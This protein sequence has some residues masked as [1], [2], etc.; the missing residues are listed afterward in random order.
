MTKSRRRIFVFSLVLVMIFGMLSTNALA[1]NES[2]SRAVN[3]PSEYDGHMVTEDVDGRYYLSISSVANK[4][5]WSYSRTNVSINGVK[6]AVQGLVINGTQYIP[7]RAAANPFPR[8][9][10]RRWNVNCWAQNW[11]T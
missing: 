9:R 8:N 3:S 4:N 11:A 5:V 6:L 10:L 1:T 2:L 7:A